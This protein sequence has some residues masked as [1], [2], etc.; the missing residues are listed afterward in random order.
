MMAFWYQRS[1]IRLGTPRSRP[2]QTPS[3][4]SSFSPQLWPPSS[5][6]RTIR[7][8]NSEYGTGG[9]ECILSLLHTETPRRLHGADHGIYA[10]LRFSLIPVTVIR[11][12]AQLRNDCSNS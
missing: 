4:A 1:V 12:A 2:R 8:W 10:S 6:S 7:I 5:L 3:A 9:E 11:S